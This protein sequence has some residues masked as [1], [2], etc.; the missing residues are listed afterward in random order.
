MSGQ[1]DAGGEGGAPC[2]GQ[3][4]RQPFEHVDCSRLGR[5][6]EY[7]PALAVADRVGDIEDG[8][9]QIE[10]L[11]LAHVEVEH[12]RHRLTGSACGVGRRGDLAAQGRT[13]DDDAPGGAWSARTEA[14]QQGHGGQLHRRRRREHPV[15]V[16]AAQRGDG[17]HHRQRQLGRHVGG[18]DRA[19]YVGQRCDIPFTERVGIEVLYR[20]LDRVEPG[21]AAAGIDSGPVSL[22]ARERGTISLRSRARQVHQ[23]AEREHTGVV[24]VGRSKLGRNRWAGLG[25]RFRA[26]CCKQQR[27]EKPRNARHR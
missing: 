19:A 10:H 7:V 14:V 8:C 1:F 9:V 12:C 4:R 24:T 22:R 21:D 20:Q 3:V 5:L 18:V 16:F 25:R 11:D 17:R 13:V 27:Y 2:D 23:H 15:Q 6:D 26:A